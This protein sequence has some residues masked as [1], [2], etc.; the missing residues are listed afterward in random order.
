MIGLN[1]LVSDPVYADVEEI[2]QVRSMQERISAG[3][4]LA[5]VIKDGLPQ[6]VSK[7]LGGIIPILASGQAIGVSG[8]NKYFELGK[9]AELAVLTE[10]ELE[11]FINRGDVS[12]TE[13]DGRTYVHINDLVK[14]RAARRAFLKELT[15]QAEGEEHND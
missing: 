5:E 4:L 14:V 2:E 11:A 13:V 10:G 9:A 6:C 12:T 15:H 1:D 3:E 8:F 7:L